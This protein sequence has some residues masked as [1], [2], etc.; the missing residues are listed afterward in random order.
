MQDF[1]LPSMLHG[2]VVP[3]P[4]F[5]AKLVSYDES[6]V[7][8]IPGLVKVVRID[9]FLGWSRAASGARSRQPSN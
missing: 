2:R 5:G 6:P 8:R 3:P 1:K 9:N 7:A 4:G